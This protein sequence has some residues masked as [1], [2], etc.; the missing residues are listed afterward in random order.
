MSKYK[1]LSLIEI[2]QGQS[3]DSSIFECA[4]IEDSQRAAKDAHSYASRF[5]SKV[6]V[7]RIAGFTMKHEPRYMIKVTKI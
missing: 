3:G 1:G 7:E 6:T 5:D 2:A 4:S